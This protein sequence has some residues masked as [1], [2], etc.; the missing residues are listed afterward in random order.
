MQA[1]L[2]A[3]QPVVA[4][5]THDTEMEEA[6]DFEADDVEESEGPKTEQVR[7]WSFGCCQGC[8]ETDRFPILF[9]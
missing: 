9:K 2:L 5:A 1:A 7:G 8:H 3:P 6:V 4:E